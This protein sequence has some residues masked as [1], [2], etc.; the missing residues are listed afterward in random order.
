MTSYLNTVR[1]AFPIF[2]QPNRVF[3]SARQV[4]TSRFLRALWSPARAISPLHQISRNSSPAAWEGFAAAKG[5]Q[6]SQEALQPSWTAQITRRLE[7]VR[8]S[9]SRRL[10]ARRY[11]EQKQRWQ[12]VGAMWMGRKVSR[13]RKV[14]VIHYHNIVIFK[15]NSQSPTRFLHHLRT[16]TKDKIVLISNYTQT[17]DLFEKLCRSKRCD[18]G[19]WPWN[20]R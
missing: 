17:L 18:R 1:Q 8:R 11:H 6:P 5:D 7:R 9:P 14:C 13:P 10:S 20:L 3:L 2:A 4:W 19:L 16:H 15:P 12:S